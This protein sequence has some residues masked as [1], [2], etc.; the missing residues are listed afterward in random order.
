MALIWFLGD[1]FSEP[2]LDVVDFVAA[3]RWWFTGITVA[4]VVLSIWRA[5]R[6]GTSDLETVD[7][8]EAELEEEPTEG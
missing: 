1:L 7:E 5:R 3:Y 8:V 2:L 6:A 4:V